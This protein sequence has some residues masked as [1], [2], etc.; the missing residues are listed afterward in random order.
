MHISILSGITFILSLASFADDLTVLSEEIDGV[1]PARIMT[2]YFQHLTDAAFERRAEAYEAMKTDEQLKAHQQ[3]MRQFFIDRLGGFPERTPLNPQ[4]T[5][6]RQMDGYR[7]EKIIYES[8]P[9]H[10]VTAILYLPDSNP[11]FPGILVPCGHSDNG[12]AAEVYQRVCILM[13]KNGMVVLC[14]DP[15]DQGERYQLLDENGNP[16]IGGTL[17][18]TMMGVGSILVGRNY[19]GYRVW[20]GMRSIDYLQSR[21][22]IDP[23]RIGCTGNSGGGT[24]TSYLMALD[25]RIACAAPSCYLTTLQHQIP[26]DAEQNIHAQIAFGMDHADYVMIRAP[27]PTLL[28]TATQDFFD[29]NGTWKLFRE[30]KRFYT[31]LGFPER[32]N[33]IETD[34]THGFSLHLREGANRWMLR[35]LRQIDQP[36]TESNFSTLADEDLQC[37]PQGQVMRI[38]DARTVYDLNRD[39]ERVLSEQRNELWKT[40]DKA[41]L[42]N[43]IRKIAGIRKYQDLPNPSVS[44]RGGLERERYK[45]DKYVISPETGISLPS[46]LFIPKGESTKAPVLYVHGEGKQT[47]AGEG[48][49]IEV[50]LEQGHLVLAVDLRGIGETT[51]VEN[52]KGWTK[53]FGTNWN[54]FFSAYMLDKSYV[55]MRTEDIFACVKFLIEKTADSPEKRPLLMAIGETGVPALHAAAL[56]PDLFG[57]VRIEKSLVSWNNVLQ[58][59]ITTNQLINTIHGALKVYDLPDLVTCIPKDKLTLVTPVDANGLVIR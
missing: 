58:S 12:K 45:I 10:F 56:E 16:K 22:E 14:Y 1:A 42:L 25:E 38:K 9:N 53:Y 57:S 55:G 39:L 40:K 43:E 28:C 29:I 15:S 32:L 26:Q 47:D 52:Y 6:Q 4:I 11:P 34:Q 23:E 21:N 41:E 36:V 37:T 17:G 18:H 13:A 49:P 27:K 30:A 59:D 44:L 31:R 8:Q 7:F 19:A 54:N 3:K 33:L 46:L 20:D 51:S 48:G 50:L 5:G 24:L 2:A 35:W